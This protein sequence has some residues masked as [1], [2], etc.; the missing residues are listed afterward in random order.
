MD[1]FKSRMLD[2]YAE[3]VTRIQDNGMIV[4]GAFIMGLDHDDQSVFDRIGDFVL[5]THVTPQ[6]T[7]A[8]PLPKTAMTDRLREEG[9][10]PTEQYWE[11]CT[12]YDAIYDP[13]LMTGEE[14]EKGVAYLHRQLFDPKVVARRRGY[15]RRTLRALPPRYMATT[16][17]EPAAV[18]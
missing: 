5:K 18:F 9:R 17:P 15:Y 14:V 16:T 1:K 10:L 11:R 6:L 13:A 3:Y 7:I 2:N 12:Y 4:L 8:T